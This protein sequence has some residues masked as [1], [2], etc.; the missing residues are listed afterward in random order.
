LTDPYIILSTRLDNNEPAA[1]QLPYGKGAYAGVCIDARSTFPA[2]TPLLENALYYF[3][4]LS[5]GRAVEPMSKLAA[6]WGQM[7]SE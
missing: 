4:G 7:K 1:F 3:A 2:A 5:L 6:T